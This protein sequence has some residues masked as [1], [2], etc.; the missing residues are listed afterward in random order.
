MLTDLRVENLPSYQLGFE[1][2]FRRGYQRALARAEQQGKKLYLVETVRRL[3][4]SF[5]PEDVAE[6]LG[7]GLDEVCAILAMRDL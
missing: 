5:L 4:V 6:L 2:G 1:R 3:R 7:I